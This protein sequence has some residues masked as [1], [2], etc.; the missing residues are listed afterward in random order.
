M[1]SAYLAPVARRRG[2]RHRIVLLVCLFAMLWT[3]RVAGTQPPW[4]DPRIST[5]PSEL[6]RRVIQQLDQSGV[7]LEDRHRLALQALLRI[8]LRRDDLQANLANKDGS[9]DIPALLSWAGG[10]L[11]TDQRALL[12]VRHELEDTSDRIGILSGG[13]L[14]VL[15]ASSE[16]RVHPRHGVDSYLWL[17]FEEWGRRP[18]LAKRFAPAGILGVR[19]LLWWA[20]N[21]LPRD[22][23]F[24]RLGKYSGDYLAWLEALPQPQ[25]PKI[26]PAA[27]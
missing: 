10:S 17:L 6:S 14:R 22:Q 25:K 9:P 1:T 27:R 24:P 20:G 11:D 26:T 5:A 15:V 18:E 8:W 7:R 2:T 19:D 16:Q 13:M 12:E 4:P 23:S 21:L 3:I